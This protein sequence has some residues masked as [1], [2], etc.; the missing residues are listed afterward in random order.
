MGLVVAPILEGK[1]EGWKT[2]TS[3][4]A[5]SKKSEFDSF[6][7]RYGLTRHD[8]W[9]AET[10]VEADISD[11][12]SQQICEYAVR[13]FKGMKL[14]HLSRIDFFLTDENEILLN[15]INTFPG[16]TPISMFP[17]MLQ[18]HGDNFSEYLVSNIKAQLAQ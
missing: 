5:G 3:D 9:M 11:E 1:L 18:N 2:W 17:K 12:M 15:E 4:F 10:K 14:S 7:E 8:V 16:L 13:V 6:N